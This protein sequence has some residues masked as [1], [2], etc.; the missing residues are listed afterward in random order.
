MKRI[1]IVIVLA[2]LAGAL[3]AP[4][5]IGDRAHREYLRSFTEYPSSS[6][7][8]SIEQKS[9]VQSWFSSTAVTV[10]NIPLNN[11]E[12]KDVSIVI[13]SRISHG[14]IL[15][16]GKGISLGLA[17][18]SYDM[19]L[20]DLP[21]STQ[22]LADQYLPAGT[23]TGASLI[24]FDQISRDTMHVR[25]INFKD[26]KTSAEFGGM[27]STGVSKLDYSM[28]KGSIVLPASHLT[29]ENLTVDIADAA[30]SYDQHKYLGMLLGKTDM[31]I[32]QVSLVS[33]QG[34]VILEDMSFASNS[35]EQS[36]KVNMTGSFDVRKITAPIPITGIQYDIA[37]NQV[38]D[39]VFALWADISKDMQ[40]RPAEPAAVLNN[41][42]MR[43]FLEL[44][45]QKGIEMKQQFTLDGVDG[46]LNINWEMH[47]TGLPEGMHIDGNSD[48][49]KIL[50]AIDSLMTVSI[51]EKMLM[52]SPLA[53][54]VGPYMQRGMIVKQGNKLVS[55]IKLVNG[56][57]TVNG[58]PAPMKK[59][60]NQG[61]T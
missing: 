59:A 1:A 46:K 42:K 28:L 9:Y 37:L 48:R 2:L 15:F 47:S 55:K 29:S 54:L 44:L 51:D 35:E 25:R 26:G 41:P 52:A 5:L 31:N 19:T 6:S 10:L 32:P 4:K 38:D 33:K 21:A 24:G 56:V 36:G 16:T 53:K 58:I 57:L 43:Q 17:Y 30:V 60:G 14:P 11:P 61:A 27:E 40:P 7:G 34:T 45:L 13:T 3:T 8:I 12:I 50:K 18:V 20:A 22:K 49:D 39:K 23:I